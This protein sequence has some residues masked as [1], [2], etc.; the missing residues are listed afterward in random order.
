MRKIPKAAAVAF[1]EV[2]S[3]ERKVEADLYQQR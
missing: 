1:F 2:A 3:N